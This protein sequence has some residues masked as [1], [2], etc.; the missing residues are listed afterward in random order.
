MGDR[1]TSENV[2]R[3]RITHQIDLSNPAVNMLPAQAIYWLAD[4]ETLR[5][6]SSR[7]IYHYYVPERRMTF[8]LSF[9]QFQYDLMGFSPTYALGAKVSR[10]HIWDIAEGQMLGECQFTGHL[11]RMYVSPDEKWFLAVEDFNFAFTHKATLTAWNFPRLLPRFN[12]KYPDRIAGVGISPDGGR[13]ALGI[14]SKDGNPYKTFIW[15]SN[16]LRELQHFAGQSTWTAAFSPDGQRLAV[17]FF[18][19]YGQPRLY[20]N[21]FQIWNM[22]QNTV[23]QLEPFDKS[24]RSRFDCCFSPSGSLLITNDLMVFDV[25]SGQLVAHLPSSIYLD[26]HEPMPLAF[27]HQE[28]YLA[29]IENK[30]VVIREVF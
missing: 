11:N 7:G 29:T 4:G 3:L 27:N 23:Q 6:G 19:T 22:E 1:I 2:H 12:I 28:T 15:D 10:I 18:E 30:Q 9:E 21:G 5:I 8:S 24:Y 13:L 26:R 16:S 14:W 20:N 25:A 17:M